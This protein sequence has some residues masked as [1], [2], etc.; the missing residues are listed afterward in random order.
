MTVAK[1]IEALLNTTF[2]P[3]HLYLENESHMHSGYVEG[4]ES[5]FKLTLV[6]DVFDTKR[7]VQRHQAIYAAVSEQLTS[8][9]GTVHALAIH[10]YTPSEW[11]TQM[12]AHGKA[13]D[14]PNCASQK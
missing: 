7:L 11:E 10:A 1:A 5:H 8:G 9:G 13:P 4:K 2:S 12:A 3:T 14:S 6:S